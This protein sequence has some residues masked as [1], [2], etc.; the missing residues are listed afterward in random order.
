MLRKNVVGMVVEGGGFVCN[1]NSSFRC[2]W[3]LLRSE[4]RLRRLTDGD[5]KT[6]RNGTAKGERNEGGRQSRRWSARRGWRV[7]RGEATIEK[8]GGQR[9]QS[10]QTLRT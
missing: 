8:N 9:R 4:V 2:S 6:R 10:G 7:G 5:R 1:K 3:D